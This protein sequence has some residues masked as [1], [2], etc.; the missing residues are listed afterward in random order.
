MN[1]R[2]RRLLENARIGW[3]ITAVFGL[4]IAL[5]ILSD[6]ER[7]RWV[8]TGLGKTLFSNASVNAIY[9]FGVLVATSSELR[10]AISRAF[11][12]LVRRVANSGGKLTLGPVGFEIPMSREGKASQSL[13]GASETRSATRREIEDGSIGYFKVD[14][15][16]EYY[17]IYRAGQVMEDGAPSPSQVAA[18]SKMDMMC[19]FQEDKYKDNNYVFVGHR[20]VSAEIDDG[21]KLHDVEIFV[22]DCEKNK[23]RQV[24]KVEYYLGEGWQ[25]LLFVSRCAQ[26][27]FGI[28]V[29][30]WGE[31]IVVARIHYWPEASGSTPQFIET[32][33]YIDFFGNAALEKSDDSKSH[34]GVAC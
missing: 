15:R 3:A 12:S 28:R 6:W 21:K 33:R 16:Y 32:W 8:F 22:R 25:N 34:A 10:H 7:M 29:R 26:T 9:V 24:S 18:E 11:N 20:L 17:R 4:I 27:Q 13:A 14:D 5:A 19:K 2:L 30:A 23:S 1:G 31:F